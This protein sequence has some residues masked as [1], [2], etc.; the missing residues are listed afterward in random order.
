MP[1]KEA[2]KARVNFK[3][4]R[5]RL[6]GN[7]ILSTVNPLLKGRGRGLNSKFLPLKREGIIDF[8]ETGWGGGGGGGL[9]RGFT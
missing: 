2:A 7:Q 9:N 4:W 8:L 6:S 5:S 1:E 3:K